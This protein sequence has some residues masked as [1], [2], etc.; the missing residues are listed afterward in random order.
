M[1]VPSPSL[2]ILV[3]LSMALRTNAFQVVK[4]EG[5][6]LAVGRDQSAL[7]FYFVVDHR[8]Q[9]VNT[10][11]LAFFTVRILCE[12]NCSQSSPLFRVHKSDIFF[13]VHNKFLLSD[14]LGMVSVS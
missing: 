12:L 4:V 14:P 2:S 11:P 13:S 1:V 10:V 9:S 6:T 5:Q 3:N 7:H 8:R